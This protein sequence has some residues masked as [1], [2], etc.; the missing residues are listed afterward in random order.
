V[1]VGFGYDSHRFEEGRKLILGGVVIPFEKGLKGHSDAD[2]LIHAIIDALLGA[3]ALGDIGSR[4]PDTDEKWRGA[5]SAKLLESVVAE[6]REN[7]WRIENVDATVI[8][9]RPKL[10]PHIAAIRRRLAEV[11]FPGDTDG[12]DRVSVKGK[13]NEKMDD[14]GAGAGIEV[15]AVVLLNK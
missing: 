13:T 4:F 2:V 8:C 15:H 14:V 5:D 12:V 1:R 11:L 10:L 9:E 7:G 6:V 3:A